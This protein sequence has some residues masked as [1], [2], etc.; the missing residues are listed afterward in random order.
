MQEAVATLENGRA[1]MLAQAL[2]RSRRGLQDLPRRGDR[3]QHIYQRYCSA[4]SAYD[5]LIRLGENRPPNWQAQMEAA[6]KAVA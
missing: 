1:Q 3:E 5:A 2:E 4:A 6:Q